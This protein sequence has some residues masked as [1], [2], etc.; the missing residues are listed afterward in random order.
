MK[1]K[2]GSNVM[3]RALIAAAAFLRRRGQLYL[4]QSETF[5]SRN[6]PFIANGYTVRFVRR[7]SARKGTLRNQAANMVLQ[8]E[9]IPLINTYM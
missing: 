6:W 9:P 8:V 4:V 1:G 7:G 2:S 3:Y 5:M